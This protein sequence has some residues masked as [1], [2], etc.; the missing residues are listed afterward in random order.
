MGRLEDVVP[1]TSAEGIDR[2]KQDT[3]I[4]LFKHHVSTWKKHLEVVV[5]NH[6]RWF[7]E[8]TLTRLVDHTPL[9]I[10]SPKTFSWERSADSAA[11]KTY[12]IRKRAL[13]RLEVSDEYL[14]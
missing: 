6:T 11:E 1:T 14:D 7:D 8:P 10:T 12:E 9:Q 2:G 3:K 13:A 4:A 5:S